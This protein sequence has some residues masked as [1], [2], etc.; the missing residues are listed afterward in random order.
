MLK[1]L[2]VAMLF[3]MSA[4]EMILVRLRQFDL[5]FSENKVSQCS[6]S[7]HMELYITL[8]SYKL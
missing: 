6:F 8:F 3:K 4:S 1:H 2:I 5:K 7:D